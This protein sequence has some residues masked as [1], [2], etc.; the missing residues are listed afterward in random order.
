VLYD[1][2][3]G[4]ESSRLL[5]AFRVRRFVSHHQSQTGRSKPHSSQPFSSLSLSRCFSS[6]TPQYLS[7][8]W[9][10]RRGK[11]FGLVVGD[12]LLV[13]YLTQDKLVSVA[14]PQYQH[15]KSSVDR[16]CWW[17]DGRDADCQDG[18]QIPNS[19]Q[20]DAFRRHQSRSRIVESWS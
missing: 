4:P 18:Y 3:Y 13:L 11:G 17:W 15:S 14:D 6:H 5:K 10:G 16:E 7:R 19:Y 2:C 12:I 8:S 9:S 20:T 1:S